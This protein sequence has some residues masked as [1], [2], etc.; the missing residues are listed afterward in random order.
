METKL[1]WKLEDVQFVP[2]YNYYSSI[3][4]NIYRSENFLPAESVTVV[5]RPIETIRI[6]VKKVV[7]S[8][9]EKI[10]VFSKDKAISFNYNAQLD[11]FK[12]PDRLYRWI[13]N[14]ILGYF[15]ERVFSE[16]ENINYY[17]VDTNEE[18]LKSFI[19]GMIKF[20]ESSL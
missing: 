9:V 19:H 17:S 7:E 15:A 2:E 6:F 10:C 14:K 16:N 13:N 8:D 12:N 3:A 1:F 18:I 4:L 5:E 20:S 11:S